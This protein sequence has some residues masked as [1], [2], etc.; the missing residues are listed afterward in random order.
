[1]RWS[2]L[3][4]HLEYKPPRVL[5]QTLYRQLAALAQ[6]LLTRISCVFATDTSPARN[7]STKRNCVCGQLYAAEVA[8]QDPRW[9]G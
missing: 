2:Y 5:G 9:Y 4:A 1:M 7:G 8:Y 3:E 6:K